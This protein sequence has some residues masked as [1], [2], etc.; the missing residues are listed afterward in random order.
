MQ[1]RTRL[2]LT[3]L[4]PVQIIFL[5]ILK[6]F[7]EF[8]ETYYSQGLY[9]VLSK[10]SRYLFGW[11]PFSIGDVFYLLIAI[12]AIR[13]VYKNYQRLWREPVWVVFHVDNV[14]SL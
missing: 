12:L 4:L 8:V 2:I 6:N 3:F 13:W 10:M 9:M 7:P 11:I 1:R 14:S 5:Q